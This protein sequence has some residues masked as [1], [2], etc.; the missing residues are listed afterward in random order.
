M[1]HIILLVLK[2]I[3]IILAGL[4]GLLIALT[5]CVFYVP[6]RYQAKASVTGEIRTLRAEGRF[7]WF[8]HVF[9]GYF[10]YEEGKFAGKVKF[11]WREIK[12]KPKKKETKKKKSKEKSTFHKICDMIK[13]YKKRKEDLTEFLNDK[14]HQT[15]W[16]R[17]KKEVAFFAR[18]AKP[19]YV[20]ANLRFGLEDPAATGKILGVLSMLYPFYGDNIQIEADFQEKILDGDVLLTGKLRGVRAFV[21]AWNLFFDESIKKTIQD[22]Q[23]WKGQGGIQ[24]G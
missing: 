13:T 21:L 15:A 1:L 4:L 18:F 22:I 2:V 16:K 24:D 11:F 8:L 3:G 10:I 14:V 12:A 9:S 17:L 6:L 5:A 23:K 20:K 19:K 7:S